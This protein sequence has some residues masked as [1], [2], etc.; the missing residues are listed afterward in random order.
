MN[1]IY[2]S[3]DTHEVKF[4]VRQFAEPNLTGPFDCTRQDWRLTFGGWE[5]FVAVKEGAFWALY[6]DRDG[7]SLESKVVP[8]TPVIELELIRREM[9]VR[10]PPPPPPPPP[11]AAAPTPPPSPPIE[12][13]NRENAQEGHGHSAEMR[14]T[15]SDGDTASTN[16]STTRSKREDDA[17]WVRETDAAVAVSRVP[18]QEQKAVASNSARGRRGRRPKGGK[19]TVTQ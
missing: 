13:Q 7:D 11:P 2:V 17:N 18:P 5:G 3:R 15:S 1:W 16:G 6:F 4:G 19:A 8:G 9:R 14:S 10:K 12:E